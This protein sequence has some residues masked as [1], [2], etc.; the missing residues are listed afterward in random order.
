MMAG[1]GS[2]CV[3]TSR[4]TVRVV[5]GQESD[6]V[7]Q[8][9]VVIPPSADHDL[10]LFRSTKVPELQALVSDSCFEMAVS[11]QAS[12]R[13]LPCA[14]CTSIRHSLAIVCSA[15]HLFCSMLGF[16]ASGQVSQST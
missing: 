10:S 13:D 8:T 15:Q 3:M 2:C 9:I 11:L 6:W 16:L 1:V 12:A 5:D 4:V 14:D 7:S